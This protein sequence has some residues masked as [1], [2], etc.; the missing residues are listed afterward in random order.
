M[1]RRGF[2][3]QRLEAG[4]ARRDGLLS[5]L[6]DGKEHTTDELRKRFNVGPDT[7]WRDMRKLRAVGQ[8]VYVR[9]KMWRAWQL[10]PT[11]ARVAVLEVEGNA[12]TIGAALDLFKAAA[13]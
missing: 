12:E 9:R 7:I 11:K 10:A 13:Q 1:N 4:L 3:R 6:A 8:V 2:A 5:V